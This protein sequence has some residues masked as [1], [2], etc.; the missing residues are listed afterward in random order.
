MGMQDICDA[1]MTDPLSNDLIGSNAVNRI[2]LEQGLI[3][4]VVN[5]PQKAVDDRLEAMI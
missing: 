5:D 2:D 3:D 4:S 1:N